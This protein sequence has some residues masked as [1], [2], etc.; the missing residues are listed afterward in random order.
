MADTSPELA[1]PADEVLLDL[2]D[3][4]F[5]DVTGGTGPCLDPYG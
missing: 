3:E 5:T 4:A 2:P 1:E